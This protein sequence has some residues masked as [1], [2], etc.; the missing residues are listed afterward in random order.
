MQ[1][2]SASSSTDQP[3]LRQLFEVLT[4]NYRP[5][6][7]AHLPFLF[8]GLPP[9]TMQIVDMMRRDPQI[10]IGMAIKSAP[11]LKP[12]FELKGRP[13]IVEFVA[14]QLRVI[15]TKAVPQIISGM[16]FT[17][18]AME[19]TYKRDQQT[20]Q[21]RFDDVNPIHPSDARILTKGG[22][23]FGLRVPVREN[24]G[25]GDAPANDDSD[26]AALAGARA[27]M[28][29][30]GPIDRS[31]M[32][33]L[34]GPKGFLYVHKREFGS[35]QGQ[36]EFEGAYDPW[37][38]KNGVK[39]AKDIRKMWM[40]KNA[41]HSGILFHP[42]GAFTD[43][44]DSTGR[45]KIPYRDLAR[46]AVEGSQTGQTW[47]FDNVV[48]PETKQ[49]LWEYVA[50]QLNGDGQIL[51]DYPKE[52]DRDIL[53]GL[54]IPDDIVSQVSGSGGGFAGRTI[55][56]M[57][58]FLSQNLI[59]QAIVAAIK[60]QILDPLCWINFEST[61][62]EIQDAEINVDALMPTPPG[63][64]NVGGAASGDVSGE[65]DD[66]AQPG[67]A[68]VDDVQ[69]V[70]GQQTGQKIG[71]QAS[72]NQLSQLSQGLSRSAVDLILNGP[73]SHVTVQIENWKA[74]VIRLPANVA[75]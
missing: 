64:G 30:N 10:K 74:T 26:A 24:A 41:Y 61:D 62:Y 52:L 53:H 67:K 23:F 43:P 1:A 50:P 75:V 39:G 73:S 38:E 15:W 70:Q 21:V 45:R 29:E 6:F 34:I 66:L 13:D 2:D 8:M 71:Q 65:A 68:K 37:L 51:L 60:E 25:N 4:A 9:L 18:S 58:F 57:S 47:C 72:Q 40:F 14:K 56:L 33:N 44:T 11:L 27:A 54:E 12:K 31:G 32:V 28:G 17:Q 35:W 22:R 48:D 16:W 7:G 19:V 3:N 42:P 5:P 36:S 46:Q 49:R 20:G 69:D 55:P 59:L 63:Q